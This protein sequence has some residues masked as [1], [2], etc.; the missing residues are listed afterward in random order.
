MRSFDSL[1]DLNNSDTNWGTIYDA[2]YNYVGSSVCG[3]NLAMPPKV[4]SDTIKKS[5]PLGND[6]EPGF[7]NTSS[8]YY[9]KDLYDPTFDDTGQNS[10]FDTRCIVGNS[11]EKIYTGG[12]RYKRTYLQGLQG[13]MID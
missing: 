7:T 11:N 10:A 9:Y 6:Y 13:M 4:Y 3:H 8:G 12:D 1:A 5:T 2:T